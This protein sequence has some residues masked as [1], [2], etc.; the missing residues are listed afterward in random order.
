MFEALLRYSFKLLRPHFPSSPLFLIIALII[1][2]TS[3][4]PIFYCSLRLGR[5]GKLFKFW[6]FRSMYK[7]ASS[8]LEQ[9]LKDNPEL[10]KEWKVY[11]KL[12]NHPRV[13]PFGKF[14]R[15]TSLD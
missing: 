9:L 5:D 8:K 1:K 11:F 10:R 6:K 15:K 7:D 13:I 3:E 2:F 4:G 14:L 12:K